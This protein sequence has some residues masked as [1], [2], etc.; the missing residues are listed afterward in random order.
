MANKKLIIDSNYSIPAKVLSLIHCISHEV[1]AEV[2]RI[3]KP[4][5]ISNTQ[6]MILHTLDEYS[7]GKMTVKDIKAQMVD[8]SPNV[9]RSLNN[10]MNMELITKERDEEDQRVVWIKISEAGKSLHVEIDVIL[11]KSGNDIKISNEET[12]ILYNILKK[13]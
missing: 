5:G 12:E 9:S 8:D 6:L 2:K 11:E 4:Y 13:M 7:D 1:E 3:L 10:L